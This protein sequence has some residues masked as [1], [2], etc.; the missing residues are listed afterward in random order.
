MSH[1]EPSIYPD[2]FKTSIARLQCNG[3]N[4][5]VMLAVLASLQ[6][7]QRE[8][9]RQTAPA[10][11][12]ALTQSFLDG[13]NLF[14][15]RG[16]FLANSQTLAFDLASGEP[17]A[18]QEAM[19]GI[20]EAEI[21]AGRFAW[22]LRQ[23]SPVFQ[24]VTLKGSAKG[25]VFFQSL[26]ASSHTVGMFCGLIKTHRGTQQEILF[27]LASIILNTAADAL[28][29]ARDTAELKNSILAANREL[30]GALQENEVLAR[31]PAES[32]SPVIR[33][34]RRGQV[35]YANAAGQGVLSHM[36]YRIGD[37]VSGPLLEVLDKAFDTASKQEFEFDMAAASRATKAKSGRGAFE[38]KG[39]EAKPGEGARVFAFVAVA[40]AET[41]YANFYGLD[42]TERKR[43]EALS[44][45]TINELQAA[46]KNVKAL[47]GLLPIC[48]VCK[49]IRD[50]KGY[51][52]N[53]EHYLATH[54]S[55]QFSHGICPDCLKK[56][57]GTESGDS[58]HGHSGKPS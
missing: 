26:I 14:D 52:N 57:Y 8:L 32:P 47:S 46:L 49:K 42:I 20:V 45:K 31:I 40:M 3:A 1:D 22:A 17:S 13:L 51:W 4:A 54:S 19:K 50:D 10:G 5:E 43:A 21:K 15:A 48:S 18:K 27:S 58:G 35:L 16:F 28:A 33:L 37:M 7:Y 44:K 11:I 6:Q 9:K 38:I 34:D 23:T 36:G 24:D 2:F 39:P 55:A 25:R 56:R 29:V 41:G 12:L 53:V 30:Q